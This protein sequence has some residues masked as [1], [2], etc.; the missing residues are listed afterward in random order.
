M[1]AEPWKIICG[2]AEASLSKLEPNSVDCVIT[3]P[4][5]WQQRDY[6]YSRQL[7]NETS[8]QAYVDR[9]IAVFEELNT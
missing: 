8:P 3:S 9:L 4:P 1:D 5:Y 6:G 2:D 7:G